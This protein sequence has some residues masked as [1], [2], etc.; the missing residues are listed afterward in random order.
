MV[1]SYFLQFHPE[2]NL[3]FKNAGVGGD[4]LAKGIARLDRDV[5]S[6]HPTVI[7]CFFGMNDGGYV[8]PVTHPNVKPN[9]ETYKAN[10]PKL[11]SMIAE[12]CPGA[13]VCLFTTTVVDDDVRHDPAG[14]N[15]VLRL[16]SDYVE[17]LGRQRQL[18]VVDLYT[19]MLGAVKRTRSYPSPYT[20]IPDAV[21]PNWLGHFIMT[22]SILKAWGE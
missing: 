3:T 11:L 10:Y 2:L 15:D 7:T 9:L 5:V 4:T 20:V 6:F 22:E 14:Y 17:E 16:F 19:P 21:H 18:P 13:R 1:A 12:Q 8:R